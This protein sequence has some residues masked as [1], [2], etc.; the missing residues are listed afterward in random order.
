M[1]NGSWA[2]SSAQFP[3]AIDAEYVIFLRN[4][5][6][7]FSPIVA[8]L[9]FRR[10]QVDGQEVLVGPD[11][12]ALTGWTDE[13]PSFSSRAVAGTVGEHVVGYKGP[14]TMPAPPTPSSGTPEPAPGVGEGGP[15]PPP[16]G[17][18]RFTRAPT[19]EEIRAAGLFARPGVVAAALGNERPLSVESL[20]ST[21]TGIAKQS[22]VTIGGRLTLEPYWRCTSTTPTVRSRG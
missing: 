7:T 4:T 20:A 12:H 9:A 2:K 1:P 11:G 22:G 21:V 6:W 14:D 17:D 19:S 8:T 13:G 16:A 3:L 18:D 5:D 15:V 10:E